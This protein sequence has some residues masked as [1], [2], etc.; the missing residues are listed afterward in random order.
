MTTR[1]QAAERLSR[2]LRCHTAEEYFAVL[3]VEYDPAALAAHRLLILRLFSGE[4]ARIERPGVDR[5]HPY[6]PAPPSSFVADPVARVARYR[7]ALR[8]AYQ[9]GSGAGECETGRAVLAARR[10]H[11]FV[12][13]DEVRW[14]PGNGVATARGAGREPVGQA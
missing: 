1:E 3:D 7:D 9:A 6:Q 8:R 14:D 10:A 4:L 2:F 5:V 13:V 12:E 11:T